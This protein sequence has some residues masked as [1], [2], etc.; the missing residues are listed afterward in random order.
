MTSNTI[1]KP[2]RL[3]S[4]LALC[5]CTVFSLISTNSH[6]EQVHRF[7]GHEVHYIVIPTTFLEADVASQ[8][9]V[10][11]A[12]NRAIKIAVLDS[13]NSAVTAILSGTAVTLVK[14]KS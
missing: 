2:A 4:W 9:N 14:L 5:C 13:E 1:N 6:A 8:Y 11:R 10:T 7:A 12:K 3:A